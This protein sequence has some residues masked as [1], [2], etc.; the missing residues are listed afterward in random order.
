MKRNP[1]FV[2]V[3]EELTKL[4]MAEYPP[5]S[6]IPTEPQLS[7]MFEVSRTTIRSAVQSLVS[8]NILEIRR[9]DGT[10]VTMNPGFT[11]DAFGFDFLNPDTIRRDIGEVSFLIQPE[12]AAM[13]AKRA[14]ENDLKRLR[15]A[16][17]KL[18]N[19]WLLYGEDGVSYHD[20]RVID[21]E[22]HGAVM[23]ASQNQIISR[24]SSTMEEF[25]KKQRENRN[26]GI[27]EDSLRI[28]SKI[29]DAIEA[30]DPDTAREL[31]EEHMENVNRMLLP[32]KPLN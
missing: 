21:G 6:K 15:K 16:I 28:H 4:I 11:R 13:A 19:A 30:R 2:D 25:S 12:A 5:G 10:Y 9:G 17:D 7:E 14:T 22:F 24:L 1:L 32:E 8:K 18:R 20:L 23:K 29:C 3:A 26:I 27:I 31:M